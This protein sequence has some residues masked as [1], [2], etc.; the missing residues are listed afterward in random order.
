MNRKLIGLKRKIRSSTIDGVA[1]WLRSWL[2][3]KLCRFES[4]RRLQKKGALYMSRLPLIIDEAKTEIM[5][6]LL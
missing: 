1:E 6:E 4:C 3:P 5:L 2:Q